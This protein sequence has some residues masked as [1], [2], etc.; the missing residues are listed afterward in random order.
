MTRWQTQN[1][2]DSVISEFWPICQLFT[3]VLCLGYG[4]PRQLETK[5]LVWSLDSWWVRDNI[6]TAAFLLRN[7][8]LLPRISPSTL[9]LRLFQPIR[10]HTRTA[11]RRHH[12]LF[13]V[14]ALESSADDTCVAIVN[15]NRRIL[16]N[17][18]VKQHNVL[19][20]FSPLFSP[21]SSNYDQSIKSWRMIIEQ[22]REIRRHLCL[23][24]YC[25]ASGGVDFF[26]WLSWSVELIQ[27][28][29]TFGKSSVKVIHVELL[30]S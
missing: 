17:I 25:I 5:V 4:I 15:S 16:S 3:T 8:L 18:V 2:T 30:T 6:R 10:P 26:F 19:V 12:R 22:A 28:Q 27:F 9:M 23:W 20:P 1:R 21:F 7:S 24:G 11:F 14:L 13:T 29:E